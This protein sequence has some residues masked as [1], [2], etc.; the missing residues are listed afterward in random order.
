MSYEE[1]KERLKRVTIFVIILKALDGLGKKTRI[2]YEHLTNFVGECLPIV[3]VTNRTVVV[4][5][6]LKYF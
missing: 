3:V 1:A 2:N 5:Y 4:P 6:I